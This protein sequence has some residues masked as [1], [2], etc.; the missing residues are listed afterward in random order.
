M[1]NRILD[2]FKRTHNLY[3]DIV[4]LNSIMEGDNK[5]RF[6]RKYNTDEERKNAITEIKSK[7][8]LKEEWCCDACVVIIILWL[9]NICISR[10]GSIEKTLN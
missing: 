8:L 6:I 7:Y 3:K 9:V 2:I 5:G 1:W 10:V 4:L